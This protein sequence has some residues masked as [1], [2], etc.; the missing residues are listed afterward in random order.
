MVKAHGVINMTEAGNA[1][2]VHGVDG[3]LLESPWYDTAS[4]SLHLVDIDLSCIWCVTTGKT[5]VRTDLPVAATAIRARSEHGLLGIATGVL[6]ALRPDG[7]VEDT[8]SYSFDPP[9]PEGARTND[10]SIHADGTLW[11]GT[12]PAD[13]SREGGVVYR[14]DLTEGK[15]AK[16]VF[17]A[18]VPN[19]MA[20]L[21]DATLLFVDTRGRSIERIEFGNEGVLRHRELWWQPP[22]EVPGNPDGV[23]LDKGTNTLWVAMWDGK[24]LAGVSLDS[25]GQEANDTSMVP[26]PFLRPTA[27][28]AGDQR[29]LYVTSAAADGTA[30]VWTVSV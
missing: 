9:L 14:L 20:W 12:L 16:R 7:R 19:G 2:R 18:W 8:M 27:V 22:P 1:R 17:D 10:A 13:S 21:N 11:I 25:N 6:Y 4:A 26:L 30:G 3:V 29:T 15:T 28:T 5:P 23:W 24:A